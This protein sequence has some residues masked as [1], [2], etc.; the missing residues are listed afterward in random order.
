LTISY[1]VSKHDLKVIF[2][3]IIV[4]CVYIQMIGVVL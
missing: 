3:I 4:K 1:F 2:F